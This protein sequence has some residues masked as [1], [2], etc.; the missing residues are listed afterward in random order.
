MKHFF[1]KWSFFSIIVY[2]SDNAKFERVVIRQSGKIFSPPLNLWTVTYS[3]QETGRRM[4]S[5]YLQH[6]YPK[7]KHV[8]LIRE[9]TIPIT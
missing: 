5:A 8:T 3:S 6:E 4:L 9:L 2:A 1:S 7:R